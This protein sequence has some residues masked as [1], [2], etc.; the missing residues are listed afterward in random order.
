[1]GPSGC[2]NTCGSTLVEDD[3]GVCGGD[4]S[5]CAVF[6]ESELTTSVDESDL[7]DLVTFEENF[8]SLLESQL[9]LPAGSVEI[10]SITIV[11]TRAIQ[12]IV[13]YSIT[14]T[15]EELAETSFTDAESIQSAVDIVEEEIEQ[16][17][18][19]VFV[20]GC[21][22]SSA[23]NFD[24][25]AT[26]SDG[27]CDYPDD[28]GVCYGDGFY[29]CWDGSEVCDLDDC[30]DEFV[31]YDID[32]HI[33]ANLISFP[34][35][36]EDNSIDNM[37]SSVYST[38]T[39][40]IGEGQASVPFFGGWEGSINDIS[41]EDGYWIKQTQSDVLEVRDAYV[42]ESNIEYSLHFA[43]NL[44]SYPFLD[45]GDINQVL[46][47]IANQKLSGII[48][49]GQAAIFAGNSWQGSI[50]RMEPT[51]GYWF[52]ASESFDFQYNEPDL[53][54]A[55]ILNSKP[56]VPDGFEY[57]QSTKQAFYFVDNV[58]GAEIGDWIIAYNGNNIVGARMWNGQMIDIPAMGDDGSLLSAGYCMPGD[59]VNLKLYKQDT[60]Q[61][62]DLRG[63]VSEWSDLSIHIIDSLVAKSDVMVNEFGLQSIYPNPFNPLTNIEFSIESD[64]NVSISIYDINGRLVENLMDDF[65]FKGSH[66]IEW[67][68]SNSPSGVYIVKLQFND[69]V[70]SSK[71]MLIK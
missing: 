58:E 65:K 64:Q 14:L 30:P 43:A 67:N 29:V 42:P 50:S 46:P 21:I 17:G 8:E 12:V 32:L 26:I 4:G 68:A 11:E 51:R 63:D 59:I 27:S 56:S 15:E 57:I 37:L 70:Q 24:S 13:E 1:P 33:A 20:E 22:D 16:G 6:I 55:R 36:P 7:E 48:G 44:I 3:C 53:V 5:S 10:I 39:G 18:G 35:L 2:D 66:S 45:A 40:L 52:I 23:C 38:T 31:S 41:F 47:D 71:L 25:D 62:V 34:A 9:A 19:I 60:G 54:S 49:E 61:F 69:T 28:C